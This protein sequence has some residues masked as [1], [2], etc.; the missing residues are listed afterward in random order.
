MKI[1]KIK[2]ST[3]P[4]QRHLE[5]NIAVVDENKFNKVCVDINQYFDNADYRAKYHGSHEKAGLA[6]FAAKCFEHISFNNFKDEKWLT[7]QF[8]WENG[9][10]IEGFPSMNTFGV[11]IEFISSWFIDSEDIQI[12][13]L[14]A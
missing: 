7:E 5:L 4:W 3:E 6:L 10:G 11:T 8:D 9:K 2:L 12:T 13:E 14:T 1:K